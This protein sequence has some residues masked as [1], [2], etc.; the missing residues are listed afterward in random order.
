LIFPDKLR[1]LKHF[2]EMSCKIKIGIVVQQFPVSSET[3]I[4]TKVLGLIEQG[5]D[6]RIFATYKSKNWE[7]FGLSLNQICELKKRLII[8]PLAYKNNLVIFCLVATRLV[9]WNFFRYPYFFVKLFYQE[10]VFYKANQTSFISYFLYKLNFIGHKLDILHIEFDFQAYGLLNLKKILGCRLVLSGR[11]DITRTS[12]PYLYKDFYPAV[13]GAVDY[14]HFIS[15]YLRDEALKKGLNQ[16]K[17]WKLVEPAIDLNLF[18]PKVRPLHRTPITL[19]S[20][21]RLSWAKGYEFMIDAVALVARKYPDVQYLVVGDGEYSEAIQFAAYQHGLL[22]RGC[23]QFLGLISRGKIPDYL[24]LAD[25]MIHGALEEG[26]CNAVIEAQAMELPV[27]CSDAGGL[28]ENIANSVTGFVVQRRDAQAMANKI[29]YLI[30]NEEERILMGKA[31]RIRALQRFDLIKQ[32][33]AF[34]EMY[35]EVSQLNQ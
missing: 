7:K 23:V 16:G 29:I 5:F 17:P 26:F 19:I 1:C 18:N 25:I 10:K 34:T 32:K 33:Q 8:S 31:G 4:L 22:Q 11:G 6:V 20:V 2:T 9:L 28:P 35:L 3:F 14:Y 24:Q 12:V 13:F 15:Y 21:G 27:V 30:E